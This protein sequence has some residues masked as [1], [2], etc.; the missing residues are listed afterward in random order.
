MA[1]EPRQKLRLVIRHWLGVLDEIEENSKAV[2]D[3]LTEE[4]NTAEY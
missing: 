3:I 1:Q 4:R 2:L